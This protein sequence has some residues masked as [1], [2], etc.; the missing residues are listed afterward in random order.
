MRQAEAEHLD[1]ALSDFSGFIAADEL[2]DGPFC[3]LPIVDNR[4]FKRLPSP[5]P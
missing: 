2:Y 1:G 3:I 5:E 4:T